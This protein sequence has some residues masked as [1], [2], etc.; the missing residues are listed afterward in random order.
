[1]GRRGA[2][3]CLLTARLR[4]RSGLPGF[5]TYP[6]TGF[7]SLGKIGGTGSAPNR[8]DHVPVLLPDVPGPTSGVIARQPTRPDL[9]ER[10]ERQNLTVWTGMRRSNHLTEPT[11]PRSPTWVVLTRR[12]GRSTSAP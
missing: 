11:G 12:S 3:V 5:G 4:A 6:K 9:H 10:V 1:M 2:M 7:V 8:A